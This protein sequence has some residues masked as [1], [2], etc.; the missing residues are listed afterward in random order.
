MTTSTTA[1]P[2]HR[3][4]DLDLWVRRFHP[5]AEPAIR[6]VCFP[7]AG[8]SASAYF[9]L[10]RS[11]TPAVEVLAV[12]YPG[13]QERRGEPGIG[14]IGVLADRITAAV[15]PW[16]SRPYALFGHSMGA[17]VAFEVARRLEAGPG[18]HPRHLF[19]SGRRAP[20]LQRSRGVHLR[21]DAGVVDELREL[22]GTDHR[23]LR[24]SELLATILPATRSDY[25]A[26]E[27]YEYADGPPVACP[28]TAMVGESDPEST[29]AE[30]TAWSAHCGGGF[31]LKVFPGGHFYIE[32]SRAAVVGTITAALGR[33]AGDAS[34]EGTAR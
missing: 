1:N 16:A 19:V 29:L 33:Q 31:D 18:G 25:R 5:V 3:P 32:A 17:I 2:A 12:Q 13:R 28:V 6:L 27:T 30:T 9:P 23:F 21:D 22:G 8:G 24:D 34:L 4:D 20:T 11:L 26:I 10:S 15:A 14:D 7:H